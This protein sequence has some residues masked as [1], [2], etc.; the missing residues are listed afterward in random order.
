MNR[1]GTA[2][3]IALFLAGS[4]ALTIRLTKG[5]PQAVTLPEQQSPIEI[6]GSGSKGAEGAKEKTAPDVK[7]VLT[8]DPPREE[9]N[10]KPPVEKRTADSKMER[11]HLGVARRL[12]RPEMDIARDIELTPQ[13]WKE[14]VDTSTTHEAKVSTWEGQV[15]SVGLK[16]VD[17]RSMTGDY[18][19]QVVGKDG[20]PGENPAHDKQVLMRRWTRNDKKQR[21]VRTFRIEPGVSREIDLLVVSRNSARADRKHALRQFFRKVRFGESSK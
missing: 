18:T 13:E 11:V 1:V 9:V 6:D 3:A 15:H 2:A 7:E 16:I 17:A 5:G 4:I 12:L 14:L 21:V 10:K 20:L 8:K 19:E